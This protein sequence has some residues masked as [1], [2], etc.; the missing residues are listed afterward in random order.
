M[1]RGPSIESRKNAADAVKAKKFTK[2]IREI[3]IAARSGGGDAN[4]NPRLRL[5]I[6]KALTANMTK[7]TVERAIKRGTGEGA[8]EQV[9][10]IRYE[11]Y[12]PGG[13]AVMVD[14]MTD[15]AT[16]TVAD[17]R[18]AFSRNG[19]NLGTSGSV[20][21]QFT[22][23][24]EIIFDI[25][26]NAALEDRIMEVALDSG[27]DD[28]LSEDGFVDVL[29]TPDA[30]LAVKGALEAAGLTPI[31]SD[32]V[33]RPATRTALDGEAAAQMAKLIARLEELDDVQ[34]VHHN[35]ELPA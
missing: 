14:C 3:T 22:R 35:A 6:D 23:T 16:R 26:D 5:A 24:G 17:V 1:G 2:F 33:M 12:G 28:V 34:D 25:R 11:G 31:D 18:A 32:V 21:F 30:Y 29:T 10:E 27:A 19:G 8:T 13:V 4:A 15:N 20:A 7:D 9:V